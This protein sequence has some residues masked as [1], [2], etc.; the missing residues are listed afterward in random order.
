[1]DSLN[2]V[3]R[4]YFAD[5]LRVAVILSLIP[6]H[7][8]I[9]YTGNGDVY[10]YDPAVVAHYLDRS[11]EAGINA[12]PLDLF[13][14]LL[15]NFFMPLLF[16]ISGIATFFSLAQRT[17]SHFII[18]RLNKLLIPLGAGM[19]LVIPL[20]SYIRNI[21]L[22]GF[23]GSFFAFY[24]LFFNVLR[25]SVPGGNLEWA[26]LWFLAYLF[27][28]TMLALPLFLTLKR[29]EPQ[30]FLARISRDSYLLLP[31]ALMLPLECL[32]RPGWP[33]FLNLYNDWANF[34]FFLL[35]FI[36]GYLLAASPHLFVKLKT[37]W[38]ALVATGL[39]FYAAKLALWNLFSFAY[40]YNMG[41]IAA[42]A[43]RTIAAYFLVTGIAGCAYR[44]LNRESPSLRYLNNASFGV[45]IFH[46]IPVTVIGYFLI[47]LQLHY[48]L[49]FALTVLISFL[50]VFA[51]YEIVRRVPGLR[52]LFGLKGPGYD[53]IPR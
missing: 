42:I 47:S 16:L 13:V 23:N 34:S 10:V 36:S 24:P 22:H 2:K 37:R 26:H 49:K 17:P 6:F 5:A 45:Y 20:M 18:E 48:Y 28:F 50:V 41:T 29:D 33:G 35:F 39:F 7:T 14:D 8:S 53:K 25:G 51:I 46:L 12:I 44:Y 32:F 38:V 9:T 11:V 3:K 15:D 52:F 31:L 30:K 43:C 1:M 4:L 19:L 21:N 27:T 40:G